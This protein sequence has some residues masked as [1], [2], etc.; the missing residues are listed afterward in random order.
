M[1]AGGGPYRNTQGGRQQ[2]E[3]VQAGTSLSVRDAQSSG[4]NF[5]H[6]AVKNV[7]FLF[8]VVRVSFGYPG[9]QVSD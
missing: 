5:K 1:S 6:S 3:L 4:A 9:G 8:W 2:D 7:T